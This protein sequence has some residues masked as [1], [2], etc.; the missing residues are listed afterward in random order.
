MGE[1]WQITDH[2]CRTCFGRILSRVREDGVEVV[3]CS[4][5]GAEA[6]GSVTALCSCG[7]RLRTGK[8]AGVRC[9]RNKDKSASLPSEVVAVSGV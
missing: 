3:R 1:C 2:V 7:M 4:N 9:V 8:H 5:C 6:E